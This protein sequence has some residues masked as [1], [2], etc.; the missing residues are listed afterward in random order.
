MLRLGASDAE[1]ILRRFPRNGLHHPTYEALLEL[2]RVQKTIFLC[3]YLQTEALRQEIH[4]GLNVVEN[5]NSANGFILYGKGGEFAS[6]RAHSSASRRLASPNAVDLCA[7]P[8][9]RVVQ[10]G[11]ERTSGD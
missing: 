8:S 7:Y 5:W 11:H 2:G 6:N 4:E 10:P 9:L 1:A 3:R